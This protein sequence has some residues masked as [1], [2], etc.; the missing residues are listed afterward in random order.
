V[1]ALADATLSA[2]E[3]KPLLTAETALKTA[4]E[5]EDARLDHVPSATRQDVETIRHRLSTLARDVRQRLLGADT[6]EVRVLLRL[7]LDDK[8]EL[9]SVGA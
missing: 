1:A 8:I 9:V 7:L 3:I 4:L 6:G 2:D 5:N